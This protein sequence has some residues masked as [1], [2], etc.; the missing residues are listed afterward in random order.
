MHICIGLAFLHVFLS[1]KGIAHC[2]SFNETLFCSD[3][4]LGK[5]SLTTHAFGDKFHDRPR[6]RA[7]SVIYVKLALVLESAWLFWRAAFTETLFMMGTVNYCLSVWS[8]AASHLL[9]WVFLWCSFNHD[10]I[11]WWHKTRW[12]KNGHVA[13]L[14]V[15]WPQE[16]RGIEARGAKEDELF[17]NTEFCRARV[18]NSEQGWILGALREAHF[19][20]CCLTAV[21]TCLFRK[22]IS[23]GF[24][25]L[26]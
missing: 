19:P 3:L 10:Q 18:R 14:E 15:Q 7:A 20:D 2:L 5:I 22:T 21:L 26:K 23:S 25:V 4:T 11:C 8:A 13:R 17:I 12:V 16:I 9:C 24:T 6:W 1:S